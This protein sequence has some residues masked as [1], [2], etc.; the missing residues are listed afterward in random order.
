MTTHAHTSHEEVKEIVHDELKPITKDVSSMKTW[1]FSLL[2]VIVGGLFAYGVW[3]GA[4]QQRV[5][6]VENNLDG[7]EERIE[8]QLIRIE[9]KIDKLQ[10]R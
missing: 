5:T 4:I 7:F 10:V 6:N 2:T 8:S 9:D 1:A 3:V